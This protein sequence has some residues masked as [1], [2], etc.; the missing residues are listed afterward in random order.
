[1]PYYLFKNHTTGEEWEELMGISACDTYLEENP[2]IER[3]VNGAPML[4]GG[5]G[6]RVKPDAG[7]ND[8]LGR[9][10]RA[11]PTSPLSEKYGD[12]GIRATKVREAVKKNQIK[13]GMTTKTP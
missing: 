3:M 7:M 6:D 5:H 2:N 10:A 11:N 1:M 9:I 4:V 12:K 13:Y 8:L